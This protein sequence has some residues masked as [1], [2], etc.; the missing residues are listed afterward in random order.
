MEDAKR[1][2]AQQLK[3]DIPDHFLK[4]VQMQ[5]ARG[6]R[7]EAAGSQQQRQGH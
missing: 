6:G 2:L 4:T 7:G 1:H 5:S 3:V